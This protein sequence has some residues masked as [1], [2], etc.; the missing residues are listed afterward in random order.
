M[1]AKVAREQIERSTGKKAV[2][3]L[4]AQILQAISDN[5]EDVPNE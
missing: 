5:Q 3:P 4:N 2:S 1:V